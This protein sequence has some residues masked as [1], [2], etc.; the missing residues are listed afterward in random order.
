VTAVLALDLGNTS[1]KAALVE[2]GAVREHVTIAHERWESDG[3]S[4]WARLDFKGAVGV[5][6][7]SPAATARVV[8]VL[9]RDRVRLAPVDFRAPIVNACDPPES[10]GQDRLFLAAA[11]FARTRSAVVAVSLGTAITVNHVDAGGVFRGGAIS[12]GVGAA[13]RALERETGLLPLVDVTPGQ[14]VPAVGRETHAA[15]RSGVVRGAAGLVDR[16]IA[17]IGAPGAPVI[18]TG[19]DAPLLVPFLATPVHVEPD[20]ALLGIALGLERA[21]GGVS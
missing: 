7:V 10:V 14:P 18:V 6:S 5:A 16:L 1:I 12:L 4:W 20:L 8:A 21:L 19:G 2:H 17:D 13:L 9:G 11:A 15:I 3:P